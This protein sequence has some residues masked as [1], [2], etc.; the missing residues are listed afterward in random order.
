[1]SR[2]GPHGA[3]ASTDPA[4][5]S[6]WE[7]DRSS[8]PEA[9]A[10][11]DAELAALAADEQRIRSA[12]RVYDQRIENAPRREGTSRELWREYE[13]TTE[14]YRSLLTRYED[15]HLAERMEASRAGDRIRILDPALPPEE[16]IGPNRLRLLMMGLV[17]AV[18]LGA[19]AAVVAERL[20][21]SFHSVEE[22]RAFTRLPVFASIPRIVGAGDVQ[23]HRWRAARLVAAAACGL[24]LVAA[25][26]AYVAHG[27][28]QIVR[29]LLR[30]RW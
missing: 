6:A 26:S 19:A 25:A 14:L 18:F 9:I 2:N 24:L 22:L 23:E 29:V 27:H 8:D 10:Q 12:M 13:E 3:T 4:L 11:I 1:M 21:T 20:D 28:D 17:M 7:A 16:P 15:A 5:S 30:N